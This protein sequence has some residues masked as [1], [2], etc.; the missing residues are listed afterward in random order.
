[1]AY[2]GIINRY[3]EFLPVT[4]KTPVITMLEGNTPLIPANNI[5]YIIGIDAEIYFKHEGLNTTVSFKD[6][7]MCMA[8]SKAVEEGSNII[9]CA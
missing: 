5:T 9:M 8:V 3:K 1:M 4:D 2:Q 7:G 6:R